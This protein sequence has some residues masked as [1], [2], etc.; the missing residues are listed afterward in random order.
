MK[1][2]SKNTGCSFWIFGSTMSG[3][4]Q[5][6][7]E[8]TT[9]YQSSLYGFV[10]TTDMLQNSDGVYQINT[11]DDLRALA[12]YI[13]KGDETQYATYA[14]AS[15][16]LNDYL[17]L[18]AYPYWEPI[19]ILDERPF[20]GVF[21]GNGKSIYGLTI[22]DKDFLNI[23]YSLEQSYMSVGLFGY[24]KNNDSSVAVIKNLG[25]KDVLIKT[26][27]TYVGSFIGVAE[28]DVSAGIGFA[29]I[30]ECYSTG[31][32][33]GGEFVGGLIGSM[34]QCASIEN[35]YFAGT[36]RDLSRFGTGVVNSTYDIVTNFETGSVGG[37]AGEAMDNGKKII[38]NC[39]NAGVV[40]SATNI[41]EFTRGALVGDKTSISISNLR[42]NF[43]LRNVLPEAEDTEIKSETG[44]L[45]SGCSLSDL[46]GTYLSGYPRSFA[47]EYATGD[48][49]LP[50]NPS[51][52]WQF[53]KKAND[54][55]PFLLNT[56][57]IMRVEFQTYCVTIDDNNEIDNYSD[58]SDNADI[59]N[60]ISSGACLSVGNMYFVS[61]LGDNNSAVTL[62]SV[63]AT[64]SS[65]S[66]TAYQY[67]FSQW[68][69]AGFEKSF[70]NSLSSLPIGSTGAQTIG[71]ADMDKI[72]VA[73]YIER[74]YGIEFSANDTAR[75]ASGG[76][77]VFCNGNV[78]PLSVE[79]K[80]K[81]SD[82][83]T[84]SVTPASGYKL[85]TVTTPMVTDA[86]SLVAVENGVICVNIQKYI[87]KIGESQSNID[88]ITTL[89]IQANLI[90]EEYNLG[91]LVNE[92]DS[93][94]AV[95]VKSNPENSTVLSS[96]AK[97]KYGDVLS[98]SIDHTKIQDNYKFDGWYY[99]I[100][101]E[102]VTAQS[103]G[104]EPLTSDANGQSAFQVG[105]YADNET[106]YICAKFVMKTYTLSTS[107]NDDLAGSLTLKMGAE[108]SSGVRDVNEYAFNETVCVSIVANYGYELSKLVIN[109]T[110][111]ATEYTATQ[112]ASLTGDITWNNSTKFLTIR[113]LSQDSTIHAVFVPV[114]F[115]VLVSLF[116]SDN[117]T[118]TKVTLENGEQNIVGSNL[119]Y[120]FGSEFRFKIS[121]EDGYNLVSVMN[122]DTALDS[123]NDVYI[124]V[125]NGN[126]AIKVT[127]E[128]IKYNVTARF[129]YNGTYNYKVDASC[130][131]G[132]GIYSYGENCCVNVA[133]PEMF[134]ITHLTENGNKKP[135]IMRTYGKSKIKS[136]VNLI[137]HLSI[138][139]SLF[140][141]N[142]IGDDNSDEWYSIIIN[143]DVT[144][145][146]KNS[147]GK[148]V[149]YGDIV[150]FSVSDQYFS[151]S[152]RGDKYVF[153][154]WKV[155][156][157][158]ITTDKSLN[159]M[160][161]GTE[162]NVVAVFRPATLELVASSYCT[163]ALQQ[164]DVAGAIMMP[165][166][167]SFGD[168]VKLIATPNAGF[169]FAEWR[170]LQGN[171]L[172]TDSEYNFVMDKATEVR[173]VFLELGT[174]FVN[175]NAKFGTVA[176]AG[177][178]DLG[179]EIVLTAVPN[180][181]FKFVGWVENGNLVSREAKYEFTL[182]QDRTLNAEF[183]QLYAINYSTNDDSL[184]KVIGNSSGTFKE[185]IVLEAVSANN[186]SFVGW[187]VDNVIISN[188]TKLN[189][190]INGDIRVEA[191]F[192]K[193][194]DWNIIIIIVGSMIFA[195]VMVYGAI[196]YVKSREAEPISTRALIG[197]KDDSDIIRKISKRNVLRD[198][199]VPVPT[200]KQSK[201]NVQPVPVRKIVVEPTDH[202]GNKLKVSAKAKD[203]KATLKTE[204]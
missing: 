107:A 176:G 48:D 47:V 193:N 155:N 168:N 97:V 79:Q 26:N 166:S 57:P 44:Q 171:T 21:D 23:E 34:Q 96:G 117:S 149:N 104:W 151:K 68:A 162:K 35:S 122:S 164:S 18:S 73:C 6:L 72:F 65:E 40:G 118:K 113:N 38:K 4:R 24:V 14:T 145:Y 144:Q 95:V 50:Q 127:I 32:V 81:F 183:E 76:L 136:D 185:N 157:Q 181:D 42:S 126:L 143:G 55:L 175:S 88:D 86:S 5:A 13:N 124:C 131:S 133:L 85:D 121:L 49:Y 37:L 62:E 142:Q 29:K 105:D 153:A 159:V 130:I 123:Q 109:T 115:D 110:G 134:E 140:T 27:S 93:S 179:T 147:L 77:K 128:K 92:A 10:P 116:N 170:D 108:S 201:A 1:L 53:S 204:E 112:M 87:A 174:V 172:S 69:T 41:T 94:E 51:K 199:I 9:E 190:S 194:F 129:E 7:A 28:G 30:S 61:I 152:E 125:V 187:M 192:K 202:K 31:Y 45:A 158:V 46:T 195:I 82:S 161:N 99:K 17:D 91:I 43:F 156:D 60:S 20:K 146:S 63:V 54:G 75:V 3:S 12:Y 132:T 56:A 135:Y 58:I 178:G 139:Q 189:I 200:K 114:Y 70:S 80:V 120:A 64:P 184:G 137:F 71:Y 188:S 98:L 173:A 182:T 66:T 78:D 52:T 141:F 111:T 103:L 169:R 101:S 186:C 90:A 106:V 160:A 36:A 74:E 119:R 11:V 203:K 165:N 198:E 167:V 148:K 177:T 100:S 16:Q 138:K 15:Y 8:N 150:Q 25:L 197:G 39:Y 89:S 22:I 102:T 67:K 19:G 191:L 84:V 83:I 180:K 163:N 33:E 196:A 59:T 2:Y 154:Y